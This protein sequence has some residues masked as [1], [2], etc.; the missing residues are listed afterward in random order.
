VNYNNQPIQEILPALSQLI[1]GVRSLNF[2]TRDD[3]VAEL[4]K[5]QFLAKGEMNA[6]IWQL[7]QSRLLTTKTALEVASLAA[8]SLPYWPVVWNYFFK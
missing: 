4:E 8:P 7:I 1:E 2:P 5:V 6:G 3:V